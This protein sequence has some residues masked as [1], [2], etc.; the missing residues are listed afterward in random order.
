[1]SSSPSTIRIAIIG[2]SLAS[3]AVLRG[4]LR[5]PHISV[6]MYEPRP[7][8]RDEGPGLSLTT[9]MQAMLAA[10]DPE[11]ERCL[12][13]AGAILTTPEIRVA[14][15]PHAGREI[16]VNGHGPRCKKNVSRQAFL[17]EMLN[18]VP[19]RMMHPSTRI[20]SVTESSSGQGLLLTFADGTQ[21]MYDIV[22]GADGL[23]GFT[24][25][26]IFGD[27]QSLV[28]PRPTGFWSLPVK[29]PLMRAQQA[30]GAQYL[31]PMNP[32]QGGWIGD[33]FSMIYNLLD[34]G[35][36]VEIV[37]CGKT[38]GTGEEDGQSG[39]QWAK[40]FTPDE[41]QELFANN[42]MPVCQ[43]M[44][45]LI[46]SVYTVQVAAICQLE[47]RPAPT[48]VTK[49]ICL[50]GDTAHSMPPFQGA[51]TGIAI[52]EALIL[53]TLLARLPSKAAI[54]AA[55]QAYDQVCRPRA[56]R[57]ARSSAETGFLVTG[58][59]PGVGLDADLLQLHMRNK[60]DFM[61][62][63]DSHTHRAAASLIMDQLLAAGSSWS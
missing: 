37:I 15:G 10:I 41:F 45:D 27:D 6:D 4:L 42:Q 24:R 3:V 16:K 31:D 14:A 54:P 2:G 47:H 63:G 48:F 55:L 39:A 53:T 44:V 56:E 51:N 18:G 11:L 8:F 26:L 58:R 50:I 13:R 61:L 60:F 46:Q 30:M 32:Y 62:D 49:N 40:L 22:I 19:P 25:R 7:A 20:T 29:V 23:H 28:E 59:A 12:D 33:G 1:M 43:G 34:N 38:D 35:N 52:E 36:E 21:M 9:T 17:T 5:H 57:A